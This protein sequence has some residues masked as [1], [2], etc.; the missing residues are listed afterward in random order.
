MLAFSIFFKWYHIIGPAN[1]D[2]FLSNVYM[3]WNYILFTIA[4]YV[5]LYHILHLNEKDSIKGTLA[6]VVLYILLNNYGEYFT[7]VP[8]LNTAPDISSNKLF[9]LHDSAMNYRPGIYS[10][11]GVPPSNR[12]LQEPTDF[13]YTIK[14]CTHC[15]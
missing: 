3:Y 11:G 4:T 2:Y 15:K 9:P 13:N 12:F 6:L 1:C 8:D 5:I 10:A 14:D 7:N